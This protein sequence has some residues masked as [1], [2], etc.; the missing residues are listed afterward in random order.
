MS[1]L[2][3]KPILL[4]KNTTLEIKDNEVIVN[5]PKGK[6]SKKL[7]LNYI[8]VEIKE[9][10]VYISKKNESIPNKKIDRF[11]NKLLGTVWS[12]INS[13]VKGVNEGFRKELLVVGLGWKVNQ[14]DKGIELLVGYSHPVIYYPPEGIALKVE[15]NQKII[16]EG[17][18]KELVGQ[19][20]ANIRSFRKPD[21]YKGKGIR[22]ADEE[23]VL[24]ESKKG[25]KGK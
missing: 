19:V 8:N 23:L 14:K 18:D 9:N 20:A 21:S 16:V 11:V 2:I 24:K 25:A 10:N 22:Y 12:I 3:K 17:I 6:I 7:N 5:G 13:M 4:P 1:K 15:G